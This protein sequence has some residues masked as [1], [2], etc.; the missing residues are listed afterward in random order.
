MPVRSEAA[1]AFEVVSRGGEDRDYRVKRD[2]YLAFG[3]REYWIVDPSA[4]R[5]TVRT[6]RDRARVAHARGRWRLLARRA[7]GDLSDPCLAGR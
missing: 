2:E 3:L 6:A 1:V 5:V 4:R 7:N